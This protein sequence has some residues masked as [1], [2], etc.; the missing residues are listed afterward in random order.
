VDVI[1]LALYKCPL[2]TSIREELQRPQRQYCD[3]EDAELLGGEKRDDDGH[4]PQ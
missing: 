3:P 2:K 1:F 4:F